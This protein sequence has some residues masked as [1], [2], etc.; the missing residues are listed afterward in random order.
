[1]MYEC[2]PVEDYVVVTPGWWGFR[3]TG[4]RLG[5]HVPGLVGPEA[6]RVYP[7]RT[8]PRPLQILAHTPYSCRDDDHGA[9]GLLHRQSGAGVFTAG[10]LRWGCALVDRCD[11]PLGPVT[12]RFVSIVTGNLVTASRTVRWARRTRPRDNVDFDLPGQHGDGE[13]RLALGPSAI[14]G[15]VAHPE[16]PRARGRGAPRW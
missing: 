14:M 13:L 12:R 10:T 2:Y 4:T 3:G 16:G 1:M 8:L 6:D 15:G 5:D 7:D 11:R 9:V